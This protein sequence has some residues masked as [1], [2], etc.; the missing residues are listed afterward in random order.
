K[1]AWSYFNL[2]DVGQGLTYLKKHLAYMEYRR[3]QQGGLSASDV[4]M[5]ENTLQDVTVFYL[6]GFE[7]HPSTYELDEALDYFRQLEKGPYLGKMLVRFATLL[8]AHQ[9]DEALIAWKKQIL[10]EEYQR[11]E[12]LLVATTAFEH[13]LNQRQYDHLI[14]TSE[15]IVTLYQK[16]SEILKK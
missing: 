3:T 7:T 16:N 12:A 4:A 9:H 6:E 11:P 5:S 10:K 15:D 14:A 8:R 13:Q 2:K 1:L